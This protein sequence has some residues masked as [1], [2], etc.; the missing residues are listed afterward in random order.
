MGT[1]IDRLTWRTAG[2]LALAVWFAP[3]EAHAGCGDGQVPLHA[4]P[5]APD[6]APRPLPPCSGPTCSRL[7]LAP[8][9]VPPVVVP[10]AVD[11]LAVLANGLPGV[12][13]RHSRF[14]DDDPAGHPTRTPHSIYHPPR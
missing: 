8:P 4:A 10:S 6:P 13:S 5:A 14:L 1:R 12:P 3:T 7:P 9:A 11:D 2:L